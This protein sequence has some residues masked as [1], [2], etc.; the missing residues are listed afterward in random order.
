MSELVPKVNTPPVT[1][2]VRWSQILIAGNDTERRQ[3][4]AVDS[5]CGSPSLGFS[6]T[7]TQLLRPR[8]T[9]RPSDPYPTPFQAT[10]LLV[11]LFHPQK[12]DL[13]HAFTATSFRGRARSCPAG[14]H[15]SNQGRPC[16]PLFACTTTIDSARL[17]PAETGVLF[18][19]V[20]IFAPGPGGS[21]ANTEQILR[22][23]SSL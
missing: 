6:H 13:I 8:P 15:A 1:L 23:K 11:E 22:H 5:T 19:G 14:P 12:T 7:A 20:E 4:A 2:R 16:P 10:N 9:C 21:P 3:V 18:E 17:D